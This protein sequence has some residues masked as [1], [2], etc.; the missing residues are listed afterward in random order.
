MVTANPERVAKPEGY[1]ALVG[2]ITH[3]YFHAFNAKRLRPVELGPFDF[4]SPPRVTSL[5]FP[6][7]VTSYYTDLM[8]RRAGLRT[9]E[10]LLSSLSRQIGRL[11]ASPGRLKQTVEQ[12]SAEVWTNSLSGINARPDTVSYYVKGQVIA[13]LLDARIRRAS[14]GARSLDD[15]MRLAY[16]RHGGDRGF[17]GDEL[18]RAAEEVAGA[19][20]EG[21]FQRALASTEELDYAEALD[22]FGLRFAGGS[23]GDGEATWRLEARPDATETQK[24]RLREW[25][26][27]D[28]PSS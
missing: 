8:L 19:D 27:S 10:D 17:T 1:R 26:R 24:S 20:L 15:L 2:L 11:Q 22:W 5:W 4:E 18:R 7:G 3:E 9:P 13:F 16:R 25:L 12:S 14:G 21:W 23:G 28:S 6:E